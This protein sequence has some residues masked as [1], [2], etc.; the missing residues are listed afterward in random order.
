MLIADRRRGKIL[1]RLVGSVHHD[2]GDGAKYARRD[3]ARRLVIF[4]QR[5]VEHAFSLGIHVARDVK[6]REIKLGQ[7]ALASRRG[8]CRIDEM[9]L[10]FGVGRLPVKSPELRIE[11]HRPQSAAAQHIVQRA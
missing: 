2:F 4:R 10:P 9:R 5:D 8:G 6:A 1:E 11:H 7:Q 3:I